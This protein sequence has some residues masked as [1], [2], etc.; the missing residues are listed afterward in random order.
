MTF[1]A[2]HRTENDINAYKY[3]TV[4][5]ICI[6]YSISVFAEVIAKI[7]EFSVIGSKLF[8]EDTSS[9]RNV[10]NMWKS[11]CILD[12]MCY[13]IQAIFV[14]YLVV[15]LRPAPFLYYLEENKVTEQELKE[16]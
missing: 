15:L 11:Y 6:G 14:I 2:R 8:A 7:I 4:T 13:I 1:L 3:E 10:E 9:I 12:K 16:M 5:N